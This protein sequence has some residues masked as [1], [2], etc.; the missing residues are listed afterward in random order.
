VA[1]ARELVAGPELVTNGLVSCMVVVPHEAAVKSRIAVVAEAAVF[2][3]DRGWRGNAER[4]AL[5]VAR[6]QRRLR[7]DG[8][9]P[10]ARLVRRACAVAGP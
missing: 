3:G 7:V 9:G 4:A 6:L 2:R 1:Y 10:N 8:V 5:S